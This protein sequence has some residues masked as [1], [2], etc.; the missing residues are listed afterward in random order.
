[1]LFYLHALH[2][3]KNKNSFLCA[4]EM[5]EVAVRGRMRD[6]AGLDSGGGSFS[7]STRMGFVLLAL[8]SSDGRISLGCFG[9]YKSKRCLACGLLFCGVWIPVCF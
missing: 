5:V 9:F 3:N 2:L 6:S 8:P 4:L 7:H 1:M